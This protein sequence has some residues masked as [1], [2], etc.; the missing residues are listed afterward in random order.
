VTSETASLADL[1]ARLRAAFP[2]L[3]YQRAVF[4]TYGED[5]HVVVLDDAW[6]VRFPR[7][8]AQ[9]WRLVAE[10]QLLQTL[11]P[12][13]SVAVP[14]YEYVATDGA[15][16]AY[17]LIEGREMTPPLFRVLDVA[18]QNAVLDGMGA[19][20]GTLHALPEATIRRADGE[21]Q[22]CWSGAAF[23]AYYRGVHRAK[24]AAV[25]SAAWLARFDAFHDAFAVDRG[26]VARLA[27]GDLSDDHILIGADGALAGV[28]DFTDAA[29]GDPGIDFAYFWRLGEGAVDRVLAHY[30]LA[31]E[32]AELKDRAR[33]TFVRYLI[34]QIAYGGRA[35][36]NLSVDDALAELD[37]HLRW[38]GV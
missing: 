27:H 35:K 10:L 33:W 16:G 24:I 7:S 1:E 17:R 3:L 25:V 34:N 22:R 26:G 19:F 8:E 20:L 12:R 11:R 28:I 31:A 23:A 2:S 30:P 38:C 36:W 13:V 14:H 32:D 21:V 4:N 18:A 6:V 15:F 5:N 37:P 9:R 29:W